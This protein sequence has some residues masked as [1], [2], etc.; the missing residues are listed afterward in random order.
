[1]STVS[2]ATVDLDN[3]DQEP[4]HI[5]GFIQPHGALIALDAQGAMT[6]RSSNAPDLL[7]GLPPLGKMLPYALWSAD[8][9]LQIA[10][11]RVLNDAAGGEDV[12]PLAVE[13]TL[14]GV[15]FDV[16]TH[17][18]AGRVLV[19]FE[20]RAPD[21]GALATFPLLAH[22]CMGRLKG[23]RTIEAILDET[24]TTVRELTGFDRVM[25]YR[26]MYDDSGEVVAEACAES[27]EPFA[28]L[29]FPASDIPVQ[30]R[31]LYVLNTLRLIADVNDPQVALE[32]LPTQGT[33]TAMQQAPLD[34]SCSLLRSI[35]PI[36]IEYLKNI[37]VAA[38]M[39]LSIVIEGRLW[40]LIACHH[41]QAHRVPY[42]VRMACDLLAQFV[43]AAVQAALD[44]VAVVQR[45]AASDLR[46]RMADEVLHAENVLQALA[47]M[48]DALKASMASDAVVLMHHGKYLCDGAPVEAAVALAAWLQDMPPT[49]QIALHELT[50]LP[51]SLLQSLPPYSGLLAI[52]FDPQRRGWIVLLRLEQIKTITWSG[53]V[54][55]VQRSGP[56]GSRLTPGG[57][58]GAW[59]QVVKGLAMPWDAGH[60]ALGQQLGDELRRASSIRNAEIE[61]ARTQLLTMLGHDLR[62][63]LHTMT[64]VGRVLTHGDPASN[65]GH[66]IATSAGRM[67]R[68]I[69]QVL[70][71]SR[72]HSG[73]GLGLHAVDSN[74]AALIHGLVDEAKFSYPGVAMQ[75]ESPETL[76]AHVDVD[77]ISQVFSNL[78]SNARHHGTVGEPI[79]VTLRADERM[80]TLKVANVAS[81]IDAEVIDLMHDP[82]KTSAT[83]GPLNARNPGGLGLGLYIA[84]EVTRAHGG[85]LRY[86]HDGTR[87]SF[88]MEIPRK[89]DD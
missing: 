18:F 31:K 20:R 14:Q 67:Q 37:G 73:Y 3:C 2:L 54:D 86:A 5:P 49:P 82:F 57:S 50:G 81:P 60:R 7:Q 25:A 34:L 39:S 64:M 1:V 71:I 21:D 13:L 51:D 53:P 8:G 32:T 79:Q 11:D 46:V 33:T 4:I 44:K 52:C 36:H 30:A 27:M 56:L 43:G 23:L 10:I 48:G 35:S 12:A 77:R 9:A 24:V 15:L 6:H 29:R 66:R 70:D 40:A 83:A 61:A 89:L 74:V 84:S 41:R 38:S 19:E 55:K 63:P 22:R 26:F 76:M 59:Q 78:V 17:A 42:A 87:V 47:Q 85:A 72:L 69:M 80:L 88:T 45:A 62:D 68:L 28:G 75:F 16:V 65:M 58:L